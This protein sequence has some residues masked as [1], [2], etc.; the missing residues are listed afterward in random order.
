MLIRICAEGDVAD[1]YEVFWRAVHEGAVSA[2]SEEERQAWAPDTRMPADWPDRLLRHLTFVAIRDAR[3]RGFMTLGRDGHLDL[4]YVLPEERGRGTAAKL[5]EAV[6]DAARDLGLGWLTTDASLLALP[7][8]LR[9]G[10]RRVARQ[11]V[12]RAGVPLTSFRMEKRLD[13]AAA[14][15]GVT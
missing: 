13:A 9:R 2:Y 15:P 4:A 8:L 5:H 6:E 1:C 10:W 7:F 12:I 3:L 11:S 14:P